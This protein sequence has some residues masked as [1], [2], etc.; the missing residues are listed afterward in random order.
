MAVEGDSVWWQVRRHHLNPLPVEP[1]T[2]DN[3]T[4][5]ALQQIHTWEVLLPKEISP[6]LDQVSTLNS[7]PQEIHVL[8]KQGKGHQRDA[9]S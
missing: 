9:S 5:G 7:S 6:D 4:R 8:D 1:L 3:Q 2:E